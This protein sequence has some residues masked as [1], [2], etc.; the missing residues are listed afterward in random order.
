MCRESLCIVSLWVFAAMLLAAC[1]APVVPATAP[2]TEGSP[3]PSGPSVETITMNLATP[4]PADVLLELALE[5]GLTRPELAYAFGRVPEF[6]LLPDGRAYYRDPSEYDK[7]QVMEADLI[8]SS[9]QGCP[10]AEASTLP[11]AQAGADAL[12]SRLIVEEHP[13]STVAIGTDTSQV[14]QILDWR[15]GFWVSPTAPKESRDE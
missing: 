7:A 4:Q 1:S 14:L 15:S 13:P 2:T 6:S 10:S 3:T 9:G 5:G 8:A 12:T 11:C